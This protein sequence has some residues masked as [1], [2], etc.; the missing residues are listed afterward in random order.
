MEKRGPGRPPKQPDTETKQPGHETNHPDDETKQPKREP[1]EPKPEP[2]EKPKPKVKVGHMSF[3]DGKHQR[4]IY[5][6]HYCASQ[7][8]QDLLNKANPEQIQEAMGELMYKRALDSRS[9]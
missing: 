8:L 2:T 4:K 9:W 1:T 7:N 6:C 5:V 3:N